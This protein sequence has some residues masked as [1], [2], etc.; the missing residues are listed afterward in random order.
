MKSWSLAE[1]AP[2]ARTKRHVH[3]GA[4]EVFFVK[5]GSCRVTYPAHVADK[6]ERREEERE[7]VL[8]EGDSFAVLPGTVHEVWNDSGVHKLVLVYAM[9]QYGEVVVDV[10]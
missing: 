7:E 1:F 9:V 6:G 5:E 8:R 4:V 2:K 3:Q 10:R